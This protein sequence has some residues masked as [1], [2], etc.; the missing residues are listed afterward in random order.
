[1]SHT[2][3]LRWLPLDN[4]AKIYPA[5]R[6]KNWSNVFRLSATLTEPVDTAVLQSAVAVTAKRFPSIA[7]R[8]RRGVFWYY[9]QQLDRAPQVC[10]ESS[11]PLTRMGKEET[12]R[13]ALRVIAYDRR[14]AV[15]YFHSLTDGTGALVFLKSLVAEYLEQKYGISIPAQQGVLDRKEAPKPEELEDS[16]LKYA[17]PIQASR[18]ENT[19]WHLSGTPELGGFLHVTCFQLPVKELLDMAHRY[20]VSLTVFLTGVMMDALQ[21]LQQEKVAD[22]RRRKPI[23]VLI[24]VNLRKLFPS[25]TLRNFAMYTTPEILPQLGQYSLEEIFKAIQSRMGMDNTAKQMSMKIATNVAS[26]KLMAVRIMP[27]F[28]KNMVMKAIF[29][30]VG[31]C[32]SC[33]T[34]SNLGA[35]HVPEEMKAYIQ[36]MDFIL[37]VQATSPYNCGVLSWDGTVYVNF[38]R[39]IREP[40][41]ERYFYKVLHELGLPVTVQ[42]NKGA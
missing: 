12:R 13:C 14:I 38:I 28:I 15:E 29:D 17:G 11:Y 19:A 25:K 9:L 16:F 24:P 32:K 23:K 33:L 36:R 42:S 22:I 4:A 7:V 37:G 41:L 10:R 5:A 31:E 3:A 8:L 30:T 18:K 1:M 34:L 40:E 2:T 20:G 39:D 27:L 35:V 26:E 6:R 21:Q